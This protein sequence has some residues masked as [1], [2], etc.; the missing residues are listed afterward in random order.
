M[1]FDGGR[2]TEHEAEALYG[3]ADHPGTEAGGSWGQDRGPVPSRGDLSTD[4]LALEGQARWHEGF[5]RQ[6]AAGVGSRPEESVLE[7]QAQA[8]L[9]GGPVRRL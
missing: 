5:R 6:T 2:R 7:P 4:I 9:G 3:R 1:P 8:A